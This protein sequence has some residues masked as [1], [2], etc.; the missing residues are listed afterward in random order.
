MSQEGR[1]RPGSEGQ[2]GVTALLVSLALISAILA[3]VPFISWARL[4]TAQVGLAVFAG[5]AYSQVALAGALMA[6]RS[7]SDEYPGRVKSYLHAFGLQVGGFLIGCGVL[8]DFSSW[9][10]DEIGDQA[11]LFGVLLASVYL[12][13]WPAKLAHD[14]LAVVRHPGA[15]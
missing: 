6:Y 12:L 15:T 8:G 4:G 13:L 14:A 3:L 5:F 7:F 10:L 9:N 11:L 1:P 2:R